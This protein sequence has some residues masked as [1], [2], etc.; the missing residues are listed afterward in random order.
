MGGG[1]DGREDE[2]GDEHDTRD[3]GENWSGHESRN[4]REDGD[5]KRDEGGGEKEPGNLRSGNRGGSEDARRR[6]APTSNQQPQPQD[7]TPQRG[8]RI[9][10]RTRVQRREARGRIEEGG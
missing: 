6:A 4:G 3:G 5:E 9:M 2:Y 8:R 1:G 10:G 7:P